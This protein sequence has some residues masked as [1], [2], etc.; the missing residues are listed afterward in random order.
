MKKIIFLIITICFFSCSSD[1]NESKILNDFK[2]NYQVTDIETD[3]EFDLNN[4]GITSKNMLLEITSPHTTPNGIIPDFHF[5]PENSWNLVEASPYIDSQNQAQLVSFN[6]PEQDLAFLNEDP[7]KPVLLF[8]GYSGKFNT[9][10]YAFASQNEINLIDYNSEYTAQFGKIDKLV[11]I[12]K[13]SFKLY[14]TK[15]IYDFKAK[16]WKNANVIA[17]YKKIQNL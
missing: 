13:M 11:R 4:D 14:L 6:F 3:I 17:T 2:G 7:N 15:K 16:Q 1:S 8:S 12:D 9:Y 10:G 5:K